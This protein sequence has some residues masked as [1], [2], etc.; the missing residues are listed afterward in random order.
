M[1]FPPYAL[2]TGI[3]D[4]GMLSDCNH[5]LEAAGYPIACT[6]SVPYSWGASGSK[7]F[8]MLISVPLWAV[9]VA[10]VERCLVTPSALPPSAVNLSLALRPGTTDGKA[11]SG[12]GRCVNLDQDV[13]E[14]RNRAQQACAIADRSS[15]GEMSS[16]A[17]LNLRKVF[18]KVRRDRSTTVVAVDN[19]SFV[20]GEGEC[21]ALLGQ[22]GAGKTT[23]L[24]ML[25]GE[26]HPSCGEVRI[27]G[28]D[29]VRD[30]HLAMQRTGYCPQSDALFALLTG[31]EV[32]TYY[33]ALRGHAD[34]TKRV[35]DA[36]DALDLRRLGAV[37][38][39]NYS[40]GN[41]RRLSL[42]IAYITGPRAVFLD[43]PSTGS[44]A[45]GSPNCS[46]VRH[47]P[48][49][50]FSKQHSST[51]LYLLVPQVSTPLHGIAC[52]TSLPAPRLGV[53]HY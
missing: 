15:A 24:A 40:G 6:T 47:Q 18:P 46:P 52:L 29:A 32:L 28:I 49:R 4:V 2:A 50:A 27:C 51:L 39:K 25:V 16:V 33:A 10:Y 34:S 21:F 3:A 41:K 22:N 48:I 7:L 44:L 11:F 26:Q 43:E 42:A 19:V 1:L 20:V 8:F 45:L 14:E 13:A 5:D 31:K 38:T 9:A 53:Q 37:L 30:R 17:T 35:E 23:T 36:L 12:E